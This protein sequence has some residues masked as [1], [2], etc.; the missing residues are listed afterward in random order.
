MEIERRYQSYKH[1]VVL[2]YNNENRVESD[3]ACKIS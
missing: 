1:L 3:D 2:K